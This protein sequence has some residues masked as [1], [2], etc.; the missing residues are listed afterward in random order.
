MTEWDPLKH[1]AEVKHLSS[2]GL[3]E[4]T[5]A[6]R[7]NVDPATFRYYRKQVPAF[8]KAVTDGLDETIISAATGLKA[9]IE[10]GDFKAIK[11]FLEKRGGWGDTVQQAA[12]LPSHDTYTLTKVVK[13]DPVEP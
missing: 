2:L 13:A 12:V 3:S 11:F 5:I 7:M 10:Q 4:R 8:D 1:L 9:L 6:S